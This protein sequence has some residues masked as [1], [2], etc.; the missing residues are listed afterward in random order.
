MEVNGYEAS[1]GRLKIYIWKV[2]KYQWYYKV[3]L[4]NYTFVH[5]SADSLEEAKVK[6]EQCAVSVMKELVNDLS[7]VIGT[8]YS[9]KG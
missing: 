9:L 4:L 8:E 2:R 7:E 3:E 1:H 6:A 5:S